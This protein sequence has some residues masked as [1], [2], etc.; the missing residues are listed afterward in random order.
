MKRNILYYTAFTLL[1]GLLTVSCS[2]D[3]AGTDDSLTQ[4]DDFWAQ[5]DFVIGDAADTRVAYESDTRS[6]FEAGDEVGIYVVNNSG[7][8]ISGQP[9]NVR[10]IVRNVTNLNDGTSKQ[11]LLPANPNVSVGK[12]ATYHYVLYYPYN[13]NMTIGALKNYTHTVDL[14]QN[15]AAE[16]QYD[17]TCTA[18]EHSDLLWCYYVPPTGVTSTFKVFF[19]HAMAQIVIKVKDVYVSDDLSKE[20]GV[21][22]LN[23]PIQANG[24]N[25]V[26]PLSETFSYAASVPVYDKTDPEKNDKIHAWKFG[27]DEEDGYTMFRAIVPAHTVALYQDENN[28]VKRPVVRVYTAENAY[29]DYNFG[30]DVQLDPGYTYTFTLDNTLQP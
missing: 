6:L 18:F 22:L 12:N 13:P 10:Y 3:I 11:V 30:K 26:Q 15:A 4:N 7:N 21:Y 9:T 8:I 1:I 28:T 23:M 25:L 2:N 27:T 5:F 20:S 24:V 29:K 14:E 19:D 17:A 16:S